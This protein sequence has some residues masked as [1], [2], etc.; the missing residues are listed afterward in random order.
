MIGKLMGMFIWLVMVPLGMGLVPYSMGK[1]RKIQLHKKLLPGFCYGYILMWAVFQ[2]VA[3]PFVLTQGKLRQ[4]ELCFEVIAL[5]LA[6]MGFLFAFLQ[7]RD[8]SHAPVGASIRLKK[9]FATL[10]VEKN[11]CLLW[12]LFAVTLLFQLAMSFRLA[13][14]D[15][16]DSYYISIST[17]ANLGGS[18]YQLDPYTGVP[19]TLDVRHGLAPFPI[20]VSFITLKAGVNTAVA[21]HS[22]IPLVLIPLTYVIYLEIG[23]C[24]LD[25]NRF[26]GAND[27]TSKKCLP[28]F[29]IFVSLLQIFG[30]YSI[31]PA[32]T[33]LLTRTRQGKAALGNVILPFL[34]LLLLK[35][36]KQVGMTEKDSLEGDTVLEKE[37]KAEKEAKTE[38]EAGFVAMAGNAAGRQDV[39]WLFTTVLAGCLCSTMAGFLTSMLIMLAMLL[40]AIFYK[41]PK[42]ILQ[43]FISCVPGM[44]FAALY[45]LFK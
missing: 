37:D 20:W 27:L 33:F 29:M 30:N 8:A 24:L 4:V 32:S 42:L 44:V 34:V 26:S 38:K 5:S 1:Q 6:I 11:T 3:V 13:Y 2:L 16:D 7:M 17:A 35:L 14:A 23:K 45:V 28:I 19:T 21:A 10:W 43:G 36:A 18:M 9:M 41:K 22:F 31:Y 12:M 15:G 25:G 39:F 40:L